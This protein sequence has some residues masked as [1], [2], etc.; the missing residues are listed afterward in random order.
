MPTYRYKCTKCDHEFDARQRMSDD[1]LTEC[2]VCDGKVRRVVG[3][4]GIVFKGSGFYVTDHRNGSG[5]V[6]TPEASTDTKEK[7]E[8]TKKKETTN[9]AAKTTTSAA[10]SSPG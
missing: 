8:K 4:V 5:R 2:P 6:Q 1:P 10:A 3:S 9:T 7:P